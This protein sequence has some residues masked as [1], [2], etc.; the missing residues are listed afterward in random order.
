VP[1]GMWCHAL[2]PGPGCVLLQ[3]GTVLTTERRIGVR[4]IYDC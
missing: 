3:N 4:P 2:K 1:Q